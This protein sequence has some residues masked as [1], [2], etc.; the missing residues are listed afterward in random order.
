MEALN[1][2]A[3][4][5]NFVTD[6][7][8]LLIHLLQSADVDNMTKKVNDT[9]QRDFTRF[10]NEL[11]KKGLDPSSA[12]NYTEFEEN[13]EWAELFEKSDINK[14]MAEF[15]DLQSSGNDMFWSHFS[16]LKTHPFFS[17]TANWFRPYDPSNSAIESMSSAPEF[18]NFAKFIGK[19]P[20]I[21]NSDRYSIAFTIGAMGIDQQKSILGN[22]TQ[23]LGSED[24]LKESLEQDI[25]RGK[26]I[27]IAVHD[28]YRFHKLCHSAGWSFPDLFSETVDL[29]QIPILETVAGDSE[30]FM[31]SA[32]LNMKGQRYAMALPSFLKSLNADTNN[33]IAHQKIGFC[34]QNMQMFEK[35]IEHYN[36]YLLAHDNNTWCLRQISLCHKGLGNNEQALNYLQQAAALEP[37][38]ERI[39]MNI[40][41][42]L[43][44]MERYDEALPH[45]FKAEYITN[46]NIRPCRAIAW[47]YFVTRKFEQSRKYYNK[48]L[49]LSNDNPMDTDLLNFGHLAL[50]EGNFDE[51][52]SLYKKSMKACGC[53]FATFAKKL[54]ADSKSLIQAGIPEGDI[55][56]YLDAIALQMNPL[57]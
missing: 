2:I 51:A 9:L 33:L 45:Y 22:L 25:S 52:V 23:S 49:S 43:V 12:I 55:Q 6:F 15:N 11:K 29:M 17:E 5:D 20:Y 53:N 47:C 34:Y 36:Y 41:N 32:E 44:Q 4:N 13:P 27:A 7:R 10:S 3:K 14:A 46:G 54:M 21:C 30:N 40:G 39:C 42:L 31:L 1:E 37:E 18:H 48:V 26:L 28:I 56:L 24:F 35:A 57:E 16:R 50:A 8:S 19:A 38:N